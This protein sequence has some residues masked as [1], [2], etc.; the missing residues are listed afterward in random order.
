MLVLTLFYIIGIALIVSSIYLSIWRGKRKFN[1]T[2]N[3][4]V[5]LFSTYGQKLS[6]RWLENSAQ[7]LSMLFMV[8]GI[9]ILLVALFDRKDIMQITHF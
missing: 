6:A 9:I 8:L 7:F 3:V 2:N 1:R 4:G 5:E